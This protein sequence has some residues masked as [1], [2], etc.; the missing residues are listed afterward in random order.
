MKFLVWCKPL[1]IRHF[2]FNVEWSAVRRINESTNSAETAVVESER[3]GGSDL[4]RSE[5]GFKLLLFT[6]MRTDGV[7]IWHAS[8]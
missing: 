7:G 1:K 5:L 8:L 4:G 3:S 6:Q 2:V